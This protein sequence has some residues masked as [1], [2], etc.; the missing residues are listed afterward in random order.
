MKLGLQSLPQPYMLCL[1]YD[2]N[3]ARHAVTNLVYLFT[4]KTVV[5][6]LD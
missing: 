1:L 2:Q 4:V 6:F 3:V 5:K